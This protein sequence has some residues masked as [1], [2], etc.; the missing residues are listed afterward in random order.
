MTSRDLWYLR[1]YKPGHNNGTTIICNLSCNILASLDL[2]RH[3]LQWQLSTL[4]SQHQMTYEILQALPRKQRERQPPSMRC[5]KL[6]NQVPQQ[7]V[8]AALID[9]YPKII[10]DFMCLPIFDPATRCF[11]ID[12]L[13]PQSLQRI[14]AYLLKNRWCVNHPTKLVRY[15][16][17]WL[18][19]YHKGKYITYDS[20]SEEKLH[21]LKELWFFHH[22]AKAI[23]RNKIHKRMKRLFSPHQKGHL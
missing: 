14:R 5:Q 19:H 7:R 15:N 1:Y 21:L 8:C 2:K 16:H 20:G 23:H 22:P 11:K 17:E 9:P 18:R 12:E 13:N 3:S 6:A 10:M 4:Q